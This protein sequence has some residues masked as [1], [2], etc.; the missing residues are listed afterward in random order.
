[1]FGFTGG[2]SNPAVTVNDSDTL[3][4]TDVIV[5]EYGALNRLQQNHFAGLSSMV[6]DCRYPRGFLGSRMPCV[7][8]ELKNHSEDTT[9]HSF[10]G[11]PRELTLSSWWER[12][13]GLV[14]K[15][16]IHRILIE[17]PG[18]KL[19]ADCHK[20]GSAK[21][22]IELLALRAAF[23][24]GPQLFVSRKSTIKKRML[25]WARKRSKD[26]ADD[27]TSEIE[28][29]QSVLL[30]I[31]DPLRFQVANEGLLE[32]ISPSMAEKLSFEVRK[33]QLTS[34][35]RTEYDKCC[36]ALRGA[37][38]VSLSESIDQGVMERE[39][40]RVVSGALFRLR[41][42]CVHTAI[43]SLLENP[44]VRTRLGNNSP[45]YDDTSVFPMG[46]RM[47]FRKTADS[48]SQVDIEM[49]TLL[50]ERSPKFREL[51]S[52][53][54]NEC[55]YSIDTEDYLGSFL[56]TKAA[57]KGKANNDLK[58]LR[59]KKVVILAALPEVQILASLLL[60]ST[61]ITHELLLRPSRFA[62]PSRGDITIDFPDDEMNA[63]ILAWA[64]C[65]QALS[66]F[67]TQL[68]G[69]ETPNTAVSN[70]VITSASMVAGD[71]GGLGVD[72]ADTI[73]CLDEDWSGRDELIMRSLVAGLIRR[74]ARSKDK[75]CQF[76]RL[77]CE[78]T[79]EESFHGND[80][81]K[82]GRQEKTSAENSAWPWALDTFGRFVNTSDRCSSALTWPHREMS[83]GLFAF[84]A[85]NVFK[86]RG[87]DLSDVL[88]VSKLP[89]LL[90]LGPQIFFLPQGSQSDVRSDT[91]P[92]VEE[93]KLLVSLME[94][95]DEDRSSFGDSGPLAVSPT[96][97]RCDAV[98][99]QDLNAIAS[100]MYLYQ[101]G[102]SLASILSLSGSQRNAQAVS[103]HEFLLSTPAANVTP[104]LDGTSK[105]FTPWRKAELEG[106]PGDFAS[107]LLI[108][109]PDNDEKLLAHRRGSQSSTTSKDV[110]GAQKGSSMWLSS[111]NV[112]PT[113]SNK[114]A[115]IYDAL[116]DSNIHDGHQGS[117]GLVY[118]PP[119]F[120]RLLHCTIQARHDIE[121]VRG[122]LPRGAP[123]QN[124]NQTPDDRKRP[125]E[126]PAIPTPTSKRTKTDESIP[127]TQD[128]L[129]AAPQVPP[130]RDETVT[131]APTADHRVITEDEASHSDAAT[132]LLD[133][134]EDFGLAGIGAIPLPKD[135][136]IASSN[137][138]IE[139]T[140]A[141][142]DSEQL[143]LESDLLS[144]ITAC[145]FEESEAFRHASTRGLFMNHVLLFVARKRTRS[146]ASLPSSALPVYRNA[147]V[148]PGADPQWTPVA[149][150]PPALPLAAG[151]NAAFQDMNGTATSAKKSKKKAQNAVATA[152]TSA[153]SRL[154]SSEF[155]QTAGAHAGMNISLAKT[156]EIFRNRLFSFMTSRQ[157]NMGV[158]LFE[159]PAYHIAAIRLR[160]RISDRMPHQC[161]T[162][163][164][165]LKAG[166]GLPL[167]LAKQ[168]TTYSGLSIS[169]PAV[170]TSVVK[171]LK[172]QQSRTGDD[173]VTIA[174][175]QRSAL[176][177][178]LVAP[179]RVDFGPFGTGFL[180]SLSGMTAISPPRSRIGVSLPM[181]VKVPHQLREQPQQPWREEE[182]RKLQ[183]CAV[184]FGMN[185]IFAAR[186]MS[187][188][189]DVV[190]SSTR[191]RMNDDSKGPHHRSARHCRDRWQFLARNDPSLA[192]EVRKSERTLRESFLTSPVE[193]DVDKKRARRLEG[194]EISRA[195]KRQKMN[196]GAASFLVSDVPSTSGD[197]E[198]DEKSTLENGG[199]NIDTSPNSVVLDKG[200]E[201]ANDK[202]EEDKEGVDGQ[203]NSTAANA[204]VPAKRSFGALSAAKS[205]TQIIPITIPGVVAGNPPSF[206]A[207]HP[208]HLQ[209][210]Q[211]SVA[212][213]WSNG[214]TEMWPLQFLDIVEKRAA[215]AA[216]AAAA[217]QAPPTAG[218]PS[219]ARVASGGT[220]PHSSASN[221]TASTSRTHKASGSRSGSKSKSQSQRSSGVAFPQPPGSH[222]HRVV[223]TPSTRGGGPRPAG[224]PQPHYPPP[225]AA[226]MAQQQ[227][228]QQ[229]RHQTPATS[230][231]AAAKTTT[232]PT[233]SSSTKKSS[234]SSSSKK[235]SPSTQAKAPPPK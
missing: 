139:V 16:S 111:L 214:R 221:T 126:G 216:A 43:L 142:Y 182:D 231:A 135:S 67:N 184:R 17:N 204:K 14:A 171:R 37:L 1:M 19:F 77:V 65:Q 152:Q 10:S 164:S 81:G 155:P 120:P 7:S 45:A 226:P 129:P 128:E 229:Q 84:P 4:P 117:E 99:R 168:A 89:P 28:R 133:L 68:L 44:I 97:L 36:L 9:D 228:Q 222:H 71:H 94:R 146:F 151:G 167:L 209:S 46:N 185:W 170:W 200:E 183:N 33:C 64:E 230:T 114:F 90:H 159:T 203:T 232:R 125:A 66:R 177:R 213:S 104:P 112:P 6:I 186:A 121:A 207:S 79:C 92:S 153:F 18:R 196:G 21:Q 227:Q 42:Q 23:V 24:L 158:T 174:S 22:Q 169:E 8:D 12:F 113:R 235:P 107:S 140:R 178:S 11:I 119:L 93:L 143:L 118:F 57:Q 208:S 102:K 69:E 197:M 131:R 48:P 122:R 103:T 124:V 34:L 202:P 116:I 47:L 219:T 172:N 51:L 86:C 224:G 106:S 105:M 157:R 27:E 233:P 212:A 61:G 234:R 161:W 194:A 82:E 39:I 162:S 63:S 56:R 173:A 130:T 83:D 190:I 62:N 163:S 29:V 25:T 137:T 53:L 49:A 98:T 132:V 31:V 26:P 193:S 59:P 211:T 160:N 217:A 101:F 52:I 144:E 80:D 149:G 123:D 78:G 38:S 154:P 3:E 156:K 195:A 181:G 206:V 150:M 141:P 187:G 32:E 220:R 138:S 148:I 166:P 109:K 225:A 41:K 70:I 108:Y 115:C 96:S 55:D 2:I 73:I 15:S 189:E 176:R 85:F 205:K 75:G 5:C 30:E 199:T 223:M 54:K 218:A 210:V 145:D 127:M 215:A 134:D 136:A 74:N 110:S 91:T 188:F 13:V 20:E 100:R 58:A 175:T 179:C 165:M 191:D 201:K 95:E 60:N 72:M 76:I 35:E 198:V 147:Q 40:L 180:A 88:S 87:K 192:K 50:L